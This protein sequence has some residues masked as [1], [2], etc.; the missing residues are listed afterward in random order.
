MGFGAAGKSGIPN[1]C[2]TPG[3]LST[4]KLEIKEHIGIRKTQENQNAKVHSGSI[5][6]IMLYQIVQRYDLCSVY[7]VW[8]VLP[9]RSVF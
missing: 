9:Y 6:T 3:T 8:T 1:V 7:K 2:F 5:K 4:A